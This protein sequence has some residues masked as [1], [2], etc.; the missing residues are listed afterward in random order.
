[1]SPDSRASSRQS[2]IRSAMYVKH[3]SILTRNTSLDPRFLAQ[4]T[5]KAS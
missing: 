3:D 4:A 5:E 1:M 2:A